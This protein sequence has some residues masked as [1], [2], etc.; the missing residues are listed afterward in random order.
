MFFQET[1]DRLQQNK[2]VFKALFEN[3]E[4]SELLYKPQ[5]EKWCLLEVL[6]H[7]LDEELE[8][9]RA[10]TR[11]ALEQ[12]NVTPSSI[13]PEGWVSQRKYIEQDYPSTLSTF[14]KE[15]DHSIQWLN[16]LEKPNWE[17]GHTHLTL[18]PYTAGKYLHNWLAHDLLHI[19]QIVSLKH[20][21]L[22]TKSGESLDYAGGW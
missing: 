6:C 1:I 22:L 11:L 21:Y 14:L 20:A 4:T 3:L 17:S 18:G 5:P 19:R 10:R 15:R 16:S 13:D 12:P 9:F 8:D 2:H 7:M